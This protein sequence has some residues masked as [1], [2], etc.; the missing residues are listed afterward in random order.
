MLFQKKT[1]LDANK[2]LS[3]IYKLV[4]KEIIL[5]KTYGL[6]PNS[7]YLDDICQKVG[8]ENYS[9]LESI[10][11]NHK[12][13]SKPLVI[14]IASNIK[15][16]GG[17]S[18]FIDDL[19]GIN[20]K[21]ILVLLTNIGGNTDFKAIREKYKNLKKVK[22]IK[23]PNGNFLKKLNWIQN[24]LINL[25]PSYVYL[26]NSNEDSVAIASVQPE[27]SY[28]VKFFHHADDRLSLGS[29]IK[30]FR[31]FDLNPNCFFHCRDFL[32][33]S[34]NVYLPLTSYDFGVSK[35]SHL[36]SKKEGLISCTVASFN[37]IEVNYYVNYKNY[38]HKILKASK[39]KHIHVGKL[40]FYSLFY[41]RISMFLNNISQNRFVYFRNTESVWKFFLKNKVNLYI[42]SFPYGAGK[43]IIEA[44]GAGITLLLHRN[45]YARIYG[46]VDLAYKGVL[47]WTDPKDLLKIINEINNKSLVKHSIKSREHYEK[48]H[49]LKK[50]REILSLEKNYPHTLNKINSSKFSDHKEKKYNASNLINKLRLFFWI[51]FRE[52]KNLFSMYL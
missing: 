31:H 26:V 16:S 8:A 28:Q 15:N 43:T 17:H 3:S 23:S 13:A 51:K 6:P 10:S 12:I 29:S 22:I 39:G 41:I 9:K 25:N 40:S 45:P 32:K 5:N 7:S 20:E 27:K 52:T 24:N 48:F 37:K 49:K 11:N 35:S 1:M 33:H 4:N 44:M 2:T 42:G 14:L 34:S 19:V 21:E 38:V 47:Q 30:Y 36:I 46:G 18:S 50:F